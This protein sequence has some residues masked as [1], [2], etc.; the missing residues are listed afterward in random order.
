M[1]EPL[2]LLEDVR[3]V[4]RHHHERWD[5]AGY[6]DGLHG[7]RIPLLARI[8]AVAD[9]IE[10]MSGTRPY[11]LPLGGPEVRAELQAGGGGQWDPGLAEIA[12]ALIEKGRLRFGPSGMS[13]LAE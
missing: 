8:V 13:L 3:L 7:D 5:G 11:R 9:S 12:L 6:P 10:A 4:V 2:D 1:L